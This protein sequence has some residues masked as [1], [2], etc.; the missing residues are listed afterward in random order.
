MDSSKINTFLFF[1]LPAAWWCGV[2]LQQID[3][4]RAVTRVRHRWFNQNPFGSMFWAVQG[5]AAEL[6]TGVLVMQAIEDSKQGISMLVANNK[7]SFSKKAKGRITFSCED[8]HLVA[9]AVARTLESGEGQ[10]FW[11]RSVGKD[12]SGDIVSTF[13]FEWTIRA[14]KK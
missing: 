9:P 3:Q 1:K 8:G 6:S 10:T 14:R 4:Q 5:M 7:A 11:M 2:R 12:E 13:E